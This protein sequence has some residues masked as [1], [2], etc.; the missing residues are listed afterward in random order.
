MLRVFALVQ[1]RARP[2]IWACLA[3]ATR[4]VVKAGGLSHIEV[5]CVKLRGSGGVSCMLSE[6]VVQYFLLV[7]SVG[8]LGASVGF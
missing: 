2:V 4:R 8:K 1:V 7:K 6:R 5:I 3:F